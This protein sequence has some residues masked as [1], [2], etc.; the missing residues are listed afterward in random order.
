MRDGSSAR[1]WRYDIARA[2]ASSSDNRANRVR[3]GDAYP[4]HSNRRAYADAHPNVNVHP[5]ANS[6][7][8]AYQD[9]NPADRDGYGNAGA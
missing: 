8:D 9:A 4:A 2:D 1:V 7:G 6:N 3:D 5:V